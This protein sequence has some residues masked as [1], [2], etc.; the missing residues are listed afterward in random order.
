VRDAV[1]VATW[2]ADCA[3]TTR[4]ATDGQAVWSWHPG[5]DAKSAMM[6][7]HRAGDGGKKAGPRGERGVS[8][9]P[10][11]RE[12]RLPG[13]YLWSCPVHFYSHGGH[14]CG[15]H[16]AFPAPSCHQR[17]DRSQSSGRSVPRGCGRMLLSC[18]R[19]VNL[20]ARALDPFTWPLPWAFRGD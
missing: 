7:S 8:R 17:A 19:K 13:A 11:R 20:R 14:G 12:G 9:K 6:L 18:L 10:L 2:G 15:Q 5:A 16:P 3:K 4:D 1:D